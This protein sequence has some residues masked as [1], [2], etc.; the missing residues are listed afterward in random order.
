MVHIPAE[1]NP[2]LVDEILSRICFVVTRSDI[3]R[4]VLCEDRDEF[5]HAS[6][7]FIEV[8]WDGHA[9]PNISNR[10]LF[11]RLPAGKEAV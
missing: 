10:G 6:K 11:E 8:L 1:G 4:L 2:E 7:S 9:G 3:E 5:F